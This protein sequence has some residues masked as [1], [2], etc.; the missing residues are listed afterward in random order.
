MSVFKRRT[1]LQP[2]LRCTQCFGLGW[3]Y[4]KEYDGT[5]L[6]CCGKF[7]P[8]CGGQKL[9]GTDNVIF[10]DIDGV[11]NSTRYWEVHKPLPMKK[12]GALDPEAVRIMN[13]I[14]DQTGASVILSSSWRSA[15]YKS[16]DEMLSR[17]GSRFRISG[18]TPSSADLAPR[19]REIE[20]WLIYNP[21]SRFVVL[22][23]DPD[24]YSPSMVYADTGILAST[25]YIDGL[26]KD[27]I[28]MIAEWLA[29]GKK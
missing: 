3:C 27:H 18:Q 2:A 16:V 14:I 28:P 17:R 13:E 15:G 21:F 11:L 20:E 7:C 29:G 1:K 6:E 25:N 5:S 9:E 19:W 23:D 26:T 8:G 12:E 4:D 22:D 24:A 10:L